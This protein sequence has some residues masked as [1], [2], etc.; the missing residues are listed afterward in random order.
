[1]TDRPKEHPSEDIEKEWQVDGQFTTRSPA[2]VRLVDEPFAAALV[3]PAVIA[4]WLYLALANTSKFAAAVVALF[5][6]E[7]VTHLVKYPREEKEAKA[8]DTQ[9]CTARPTPAGAS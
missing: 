9:H 4:G 8:A 3:Y 7:V 6:M 5:L 1:M 2:I